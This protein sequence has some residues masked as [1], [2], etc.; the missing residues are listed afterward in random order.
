MR[1]FPFAASLAGLAC[2]VGTTTAFSADL[3]PYHI[4]RRTHAPRLEALP[5]APPL[6]R[7]T[8]ERLYTRPVVGFYGYPYDYGMPRSQGGPP[9]AR[10]PY[11]LRRDGP[12]GVD[13][14]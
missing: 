12:H 7:Q 3:G 11:I 6:I 10:E 8:E 4:R 9:G 2:L 1:S 13:V 14:N 5:P